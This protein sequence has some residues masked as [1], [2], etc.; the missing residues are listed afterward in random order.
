MTIQ[1][2]ITHVQAAIAASSATTVQFAPEY[3]TDNMISVV[4]SEA[5]ATN[6]R[7]SGGADNKLTLFELHINIMYPRAAL[8]D[9]M[10]AI[11]GIPLAVANIFRNDVSI[12][13]HAETIGEEITCNLAARPIAGIDH[14]G[15]AFVIPDVKLHE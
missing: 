2:V 1:A 15:W 10:Q 6:I 9:V 5:Y 13:G 3:P 7:F 14:V 12:G 8:E 11:A 4:T